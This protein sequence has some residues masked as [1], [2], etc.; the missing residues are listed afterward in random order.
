[1]LIL[2]RRGATREE[3]DLA[4]WLTLPGSAPLRGR[5]LDLSA[6]GVLARVDRP[7]LLQP[8]QTLDANLAFDPDD[9]DP[10]AA[11]P[12]RAR[13]TRSFGFGEVQHVALS[14]DRPV[15]RGQTPS[16][17]RAG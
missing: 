13:V 1:M 11:E 17:R 8:G 9:T 10:R 4:L 5:T 6:S 15:G 7:A 12:L 14:F 3:S 16:T 2:E